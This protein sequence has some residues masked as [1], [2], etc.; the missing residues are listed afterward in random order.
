MERGVVLN[1]EGAS[2]LKAAQ[3]VKGGDTSPKQMVLAI[4]DEEHAQTTKLHG[5]GRHSGRR[6]E[7]VQEA[8]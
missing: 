2:G 3:S 5:S 4:S 7:Q 1:R 8:M 6:G